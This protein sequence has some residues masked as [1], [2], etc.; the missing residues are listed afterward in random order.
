MRG[1][2]LLLVLVSGSC[3]ADV[4]IDLAKAV[5]DESVGQFCVMQRVCV[6][7]PPEALTSA[8]CAPMFPPGCDCR[9]WS[10]K[11]FVTTIFDCQVILL[12]MIQTPRVQLVRP[13]SS[14]SVC[15]WDVTVTPMLR[16]QTVSAPVEMCARTARVSLPSL[17]AATVTPR[18][19]MLTPAAALATPVSSASVCPGAV[20]ATPWRTIP[21]TF[22]LLV[23]HV[24]TASVRDLFLP[25]AS[26]TLSP[27]TQTISAPMISGLF[28][29]SLQKSQIII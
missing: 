22:V 23:R 28:Y 29:Q 6:A 10:R 12:R 18:L 27:P 19:M 4:T 21:M 26:A 3:L 24:R 16:I 15:P 8:G 7:N 11:L 13:V 17:P 1:S 14:A 25:A 9:T 20:T 2:A 5:F